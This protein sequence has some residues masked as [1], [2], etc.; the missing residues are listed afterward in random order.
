MTRGYLLDTSV[1]STVAP[2]RPPIT[3]AEAGWLRQQA[4]RLYIPTIAIAEIEAG[5]RKLHRSGGTA[6]AE[7][8][9]AWLDGLIAGYGDR[10]LAF[11]AD[12]A[13]VAGRLAD[14][15]IAAGRHPGFAD[16]AIAA[17]ATARDL[18]LLTRNLRH[19]E[20][21]G[22]PAADPFAALPDH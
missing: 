15:A 1:I 8:L 5:I 2:G 6:R 9:A 11:D 10:I 13:R 14:A 22:I 19:F 7:H 20:P 4:D 21:L 16:V 12:T 18:T 3:D 17:I